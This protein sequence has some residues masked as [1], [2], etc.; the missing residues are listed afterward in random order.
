M[1]TET[2]SLN[3]TVYAEAVAGVTDPAVVSRVPTFTCTRP[4]AMAEPGSASPFTSRFN[5]S[6]GC[7][8]LLA[9]SLLLDRS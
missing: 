7:A 5:T 8:G 3:C 2:S 9:S 6:P 1:G 4:G